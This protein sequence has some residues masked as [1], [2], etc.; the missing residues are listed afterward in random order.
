MLKDVR[1]EAG[2]GDPPRDY[3]NN[4]PEAANF[5]IKH[6]LHFDSKKPHHFI[7]EIKNIVE[8]QQRNGDRAVFGKG[9]YRVRKQFEHLMVDDLGSIDPPAAREETVGVLG[10]R[11]G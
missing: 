9:P 2:L 10:E 6:G 8:T 1:I 5:I 3:V 4:N 11:N 7:E